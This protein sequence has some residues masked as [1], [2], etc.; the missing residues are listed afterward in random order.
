MPSSASSAYSSSV[1]PTMFLNTCSLSSPSNGAERQ[2]SLRA[3]EIDAN[4]RPH[5]VDR[6]LDVKIPAGVRPGQY[7]RLAGQ[8]MPQLKGGGR[9][10]LTVRRGTVGL[11][12]AHG[13]ELVLQFGIGLC[14]QCLVDHIDLGF[15]CRFAQC[16]HTFGTR[17]QIF[18]QQLADTQRRF[19][20]AAHAVVVDN[21]FSTCGQLGGLAS[22]CVLHF[23]AIDDVGLVGGH[24][25]GVCGAC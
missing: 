9:G 22:G 13:L 24:F 8:G 16:I 6:T 15:I 4:G 20:F 5:L 12:C 25:D 19:N 3:Q 23:I 21:V 14:S 10:D 7:I 18:G 17:G 1:I 2:L 11:E